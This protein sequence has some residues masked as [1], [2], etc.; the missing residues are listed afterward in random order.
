VTAA[1]AP[2]LVVPDLLQ[3][4]WSAALIT[5]FGA[6]LTFF[7][8]KLA[9]QLSQVPLRMILADGQMLS[10]RLREA[11][12][13]GQRLR[14]IGRSYLA[15]P[16]R[17]AG[18][19][20]AKVILLLAPREGRLM[21]GSG[22]LG[23]EGYASPGE[24]W[25]VFGY[26]DER[27]HHVAEFAAAR[28]L[29]DGLAIRSLLDPPA[30]GL[31]AAVWSTAP[32]LPPTPATATA[33]R[34][35]LDRP[36]LDQLA[37]TVDWP[38]RDLVVHA[39]FHDPD[40]AALAALIEQFTPAKV[41]VL[42]SKA[43]SIDAH[44]LTTVL[45]TAKKS[46]VELVEVTAEPGA[47]L[48]AKW[49]HLRGASY[50]ALLTGSANLSRSALLRAT[51]DGNI[52]TGV[53]TTGAPG[54]FTGLYEH[55]R[56][57]RL[58][59]LSA[60]GLR[61]QPIQP[62][63]PPP[64]HP[65]VLWSRLDRTRLT[66]MFDQAIGTGSI[67]VTF[68][69]TSLSWS[70]MRVRGPAVE[71]DLDDVSAARVAD[72]GPLTIELDAAGPGAQPSYTWPYQIEAIRHRLDM[73]SQRDRLPYIANLPDR[74]A[75]LYASLQ[76]LEQ[77]LV[78]DPV[79]A[80]R[81]A[82][83]GTELPAPAA[84]DGVIGWHDLD[85]DRVRRDPRYAGYLTPGHRAEVSPTDIQ[86]ILASIAGRLSELGT[87]AAADPAAADDE[88]DLAHE[89]DTEVST[90]DEGAQDRQ[91]D[92]IVRR[93]LPITTRTRMAFTRFVKR[94]TA[95]TK[96]SA[97]VNELGPVVAATNAAIFNHLLAQLLERDIVDVSSATNAQVALWSLLWG[98]PTAPGLVAYVDA[99]QRSTI[100]KVLAEGKVRETTL[101]WLAGSGELDL[102][103]VSERAVRDVA[104]HL[105]VNEDFNLDEPL[106]RAAQPNPALA[107][108]LLGQLIEV[109]SASVQNELDDLVLEPLG[110][111]HR[112]AEW[113]KGRVPRGTATIN[114]DV[115]VVHTPV[116]RL[117]HV[118]VRQALE[119]LAVASFLGG[120]NIDEYLRIR[121]QGN[122]S[123]VGFWDEQA[124]VGVTLV[125]GDA[126]DFDIFQPPWPD[127]LGRLDGLQAVLL[128][129][130]TTP[131]IA[132][133][134][135]SAV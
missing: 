29:I 135:R 89:S 50:E 127:W 2:T 21:V 130:F 107:A 31:L 4:Q 56:R 62:P 30:A 47:Y 64:Q 33:V 7:N 19:A 124:G 51:A 79:S 132:G 26:H 12:T 40:C 17:H 37:D 129:A 121:F 85:W 82:R 23:P 81:V 69:E 5:T 88:D 133:A 16:V 122:R 106:V 75:D 126:V 8:A 24:L 71:I 27:P 6:D 112:D 49:L 54:T 102:D 119:R 28:T 73:T 10:L 101:R 91:D 98:T 131:P 95:A 78:F 99:P 83:P 53:I 103:P 110:L 22:N 116:A 11:A 114:A 115:L 48:H 34:H 52:E 118:R 117:S 96:D 72:G 87:P 80:W 97:F 60:V 74:D 43:T 86:V 70:A 66:V 93:A 1:A 61:L 67:T 128:A 20:H 94:Y 18:A 38:V 57:T 55:L 123:D 125:D 111:T 120:W 84:D 100:E 58:D 105:I 104:R 36:L 68:A 9:R 42:V 3:G 108:A 76:E 35:N 134:T 90:E 14:S 13:T 109:A 32:W 92:E 41:T 44:R 46:T 59:D 113:D 25:H 63:P 45:A 15:A 39:P 77:T 65:V